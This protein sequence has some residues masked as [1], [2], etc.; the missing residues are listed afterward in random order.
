MYK[1]IKMSF[2]GWTRT[3]EDRGKLASALYPHICEKCI[4]MY[5]KELD[6]MLNSICGLDFEMVGPADDEALTEAEQSDVD[7]NG[8]GS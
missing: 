7:L 4:E 1:L 5:G 8:C 6:Q 3:Y 2:P